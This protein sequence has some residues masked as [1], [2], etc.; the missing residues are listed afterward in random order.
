MKNAND[1]SCFVNV[2]FISFREKTALPEKMFI[3]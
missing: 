2:S 3:V 1:L